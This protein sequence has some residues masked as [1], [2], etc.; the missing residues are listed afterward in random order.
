MT[1]GDVMD[2]SA[3]L[4]NDSSRSR[5]TYAVQMPYLNMAMAE[6]EEMFE[7]NNVPSTNKTSAAITVEAGVDTLSFTTTPALP[8]DLKEIQELWEK[9]SGISEDYIPMIHREFLPKVDVLTTNLIYWSWIDQEIKFIG[10]TSDRDV[11]IDY[12]KSIFSK[13]QANTDQITVINCKSF[14]MYRTAGLVAEFIGENTSRA[15]S[16]NAD[17]LLALDRTLGISVKGKQNISTRRQPFRSGYKRGAIY[18]GR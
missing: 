9:D 13:V 16:L 7:L 8:S 17:A 18:T 2:L 6:L 15:E 3:S 5:F 11:K 10:A 4:L 14:L 12:I 1:A